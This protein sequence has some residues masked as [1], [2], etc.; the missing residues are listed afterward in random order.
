MKIPQALHW[1]LAL[2]NR[3]V[4]NTGSSRQLLLQQGKHEV[5]PRLEVAVEGLGRHPGPGHQ[6]GDG[7]VFVAV[8]QI[9]SGP[10]Q[11]AELIVGPP[12]GRSQRSLVGTVLPRWRWRNRL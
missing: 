10:D 6:G 8:E 3:I 11:T 7:H 9:L 5:V 2:G 4:E 12:S 1:I